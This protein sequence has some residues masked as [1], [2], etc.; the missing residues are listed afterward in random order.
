[1]SSRV[2]TLGVEWASGEELLLAVSPVFK[3]RYTH[4][5]DLVLGCRYGCEFCYYRW[6]RASRDYIGTGR[7]KRLTTPRGMVEFLEKS[8]LFLPT[9]I[10]ILGARGDASM[11]PREVVQLLRLLEE[12]SRFEGNTVLVLH[13]APVSKTMEKALTDYPRLMFGTTITPRGY[14]LGWTRIR[15]EAQL[16]GLKGL[17]ETGVDPD[18]I[19]VEIGPLNE[20][21]LEEGARILRRLEEMG[22]K[23]AIVR[24]VSFGTF[25]VDRERELRRMVDL[26]FL[27]SSLLKSPERHEYYVVKNYL[28]S[29]VYRAL[30]EA[31]PKMRLHRHTYTYYREVWGVPI[32]LNRDNRVRISR[33]ATHPEDRVRAAV[34]RYGLRPE[35]VARRGDHYYVELPEGQTAT[36]DIAMTVGAE[37]ETAVIFNNYRRTPSL[38]DVEFYRKNSLFYLDSYL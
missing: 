5:G 22:F 26:G 10:L 19:P 8:K 9:D 24:G 36:E 12:D 37:L 1:M 34:E 13:R 25:G 15:E 21:N 7:L 4:D 14:E 27:D 18:R 11:Y 3:R 23:N 6:I 2:Q 31:V 30:Q 28:V 17:L 16:A 32:A 29:E 33:P 35:S 38:E 20:K